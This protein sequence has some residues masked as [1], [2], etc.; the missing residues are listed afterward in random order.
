MPCKLRQKC[1]IKSQININELNKLTSNIS[2]I[3]RNYK[4]QPTNVH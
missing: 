4:Y 1:V 3:K 2:E